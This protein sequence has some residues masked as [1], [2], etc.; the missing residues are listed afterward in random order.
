MYMITIFLSFF[1]FNMD[2]FFLVGGILFCADSS[3]QGS[4]VQWFA[5]C[6]DEENISICLTFPNQYKIQGG[7]QLL[8]Y[9]FLPLL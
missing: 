9:Y 8:L 1:I 3:E 6:F 2:T 4:N 7:L 5:K